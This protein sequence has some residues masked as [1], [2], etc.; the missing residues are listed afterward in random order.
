MDKVVK[1]L[2]KS[3]LVNIFLVIIKLIIGFIGNSKALIANAVHSL[4]DLITDVISIVG[5]KMS[6]KSADERHP[7]GFGQIEYLTNIIVSFVIFY[8]GLQSIM[9][10]FNN[11][12]NIPSDII[13]VISLLTAIIKYG[14]STYIYNKGKIYQN[15]ILV[16]S[17]IE[18]RADAL[19]SSLVVLSVIFAKLTP[20]IYIYKYSDNVCTFIIGIYI[21][22]VAIKILKENIVNIIGTT[23]ED[24]YMIQDLK[25]II[26]GEKEV[27]SVDEL[28][29]IKYGSYYVAIIELTL[30]KNL[31][32]TKIN[33]LKKRIR[34]NIN[35]YDSK[36]TYIKLSV[37]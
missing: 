20:Y 32:L 17:G 23:P 31:K 3:F 4:S 1:V 10:A 8:L 16:V 22:Y 15:G 13:L 28:S 11:K 27:L 12:I 2:L 26:E 19:T 5:Y 33:K 21:I 35:V 24:E 18:S 7:L 6:K 29:V 34:S 30:N 36:I 9:S 25:S 14:L 37:N